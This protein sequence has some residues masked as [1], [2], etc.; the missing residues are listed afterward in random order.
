MPTL[1][2]EVSFDEWSH[3]R[4]LFQLLFPRRQ[5]NKNPTQDSSAR[6]TPHAA[7][8]KQ[9]AASKPLLLALQ[10]DPSRRKNLSVSL[11]P[12]AL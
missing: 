5:G 6:P 7:K 8:S 4:C 10:V 11:L 3:H 2:N 1:D 9:I 12:L